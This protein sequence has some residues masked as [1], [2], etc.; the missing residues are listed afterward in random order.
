MIFL[1]DDGVEYKECYF[2]MVDY[3]AENGYGGYGRNSICAHI[4]ESI[5]GKKETSLLFL[6]EDDITYK[7]IGKEFEKM[8]EKYIDEEGMIP[9]DIKKIIQAIDK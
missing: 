9:I 5:D 1:Q 4:T 6:D 3:S 7:L 8:L 2:V